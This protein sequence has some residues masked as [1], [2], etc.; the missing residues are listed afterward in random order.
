MFRNS[1]IPLLSTLEA[2]HLLSPRVELNNDTPSVRENWYCRT[3]EA[4]E[5]LGSAISKEL[6]DSQ[7]FKIN[8]V[9]R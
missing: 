6:I 2:V 9:T 5:N 7:P 3:R 4:S 8:V 1:N